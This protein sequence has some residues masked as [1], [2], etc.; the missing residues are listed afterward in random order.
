MS[1]MIQYT[2]QL[3]SLTSHSKTSIDNIV[4]N[5]FSCEAIPRDITVTISDHLPQSLFAPNMLSNPLCNKLKILKKDW[6]R[7]NQ[8]SLILDYFDKNWSGILQLDQETVKLSI[9]SYLDHINSVLDNY[10]PFKQVKCKLR[11]KSNTG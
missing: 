10:A 4:S 2:L 6:S 9:E 7:F 5:A 8:E 1:S 3:T 11:L